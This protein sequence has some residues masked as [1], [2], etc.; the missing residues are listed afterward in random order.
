MK[1][2]NLTMRHWMLLTGSCLLVIFHLWG[3]RYSLLHARLSSAV[4][5]S[6]VILVAIKHVGLLG[7]VYA[8]FR[9]RPRK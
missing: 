4:L 8:R 5:V 6:A 2:R 1:P 3:F 9:R 7:P